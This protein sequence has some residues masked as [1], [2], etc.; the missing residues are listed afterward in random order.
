MSDRQANLSSLLDE[1]LM[2]AFRLGDPDAFTVLYGRYSKRVYGFLLKR[3]SSTRADDVFQDTFLKLHKY[4]A[5]YDSS[6][7][8][9]PW[10]F[11]LCRTA[12]IDMLRKEKNVLAAAELR[13]VPQEESTVSYSDY[14][15]AMELL[16]ALSPREQ[17][18]LRLRIF[19]DLPFADVAQRIGLTVVNIRKIA[20]R[21]LQR[22][23]NIAD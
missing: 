19:E 12:L 9:A 5:R 15:R 2:E 3:V 14:G 11:S 16:D 18:I 21:A 6:R 10:L 7:P 20:S 13:D 4:R 8:F 22:L 1:E 23:R 17:E